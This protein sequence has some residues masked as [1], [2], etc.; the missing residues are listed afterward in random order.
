VHGLA[1]FGLT[2]KDLSIGLD[3]R[4]QIKLGT[5]RLLTHV[6]PL[7]QTAVF[8]PLHLSGRLSLVPL[9]FP[10]EAIYRCGMHTTIAILL[11]LISQPLEDGQSHMQ[12]NIKEISPFAVLAW[13]K[14]MLPLGVD[15]W[16]N[17]P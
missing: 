6:L 7:A 12:S 8:T 2:L 14:I 1:A 11:F 9:L 15:N 10:M 17:F 5:R 16:L 4:A 13:T 3:P